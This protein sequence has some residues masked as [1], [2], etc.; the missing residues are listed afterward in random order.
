MTKKLPKSTCM[1]LV[2]GATIGFWAWVV[3]PI[4]KVEI[5]IPALAGLAFSVLFSASCKSQCGYRFHVASY[6]IGVA[7][8]AFA[9]FFVQIQVSWFMLVSC[10]L[11]QAVFPLVAY[12]LEATSKV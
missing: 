9:C 6:A 8:M 1:R 10:I 3:L 7:F 4:I 12:A 2:L 5:L 11:M